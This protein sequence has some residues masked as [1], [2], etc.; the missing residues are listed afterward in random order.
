MAEPVTLYN[1]EGESITVY[2]P[3]EVVRLAAAGWA[4]RVEATQAAQP[5]APAADASSAPGEHTLP[6][7]K[8]KDTTKEAMR[9]PTAKPRR[10]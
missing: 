7:D 5:P 9:A 2:A 10:T 3:S 6:A 8:R 1:A 4:M